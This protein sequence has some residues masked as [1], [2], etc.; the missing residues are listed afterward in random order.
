M[1][2]LFRSGASQ[3]L[4]QYELWI[5]SSLCCISEVAVAREGLKMNCS[6]G[7]VS[8]LVFLLGGLDECFRIATVW[9]IAQHV[10]LKKI[11]TA[12]TLENWGGLI[13]CYDARARCALFIRK[14]EMSAML[15]CTEAMT[16]LRVAS[17]YEGVPRVASVF[18]R[19]WHV[20]YRDDGS[21]QRRVEAKWCTI[22]T[23]FCFY[24]PI[25]IAVI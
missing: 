3:S 2:A 15:A 16:P 9:L 12:L 6:G 4:S 13:C 7:E 17:I 25:C 1:G 11:I 22:I 18:P 20:A 21:E 5:L 19:K 24:A 23:P 14:A 10:F 8:L